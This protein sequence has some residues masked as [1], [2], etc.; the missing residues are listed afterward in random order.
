MKHNGEQQPNSARNPDAILAEIQR[1]RGEMDSTLTALE[2][3]LTPGQLVD[4]GIDYLRKSGANE[5]VQN[6]G[7]QAKNNPM[8]IALVG[9]GL[10]WLM[11]SG[12]Q[13]PSRSTSTS[14]IDAGGSSIGNR[15]GE[16]RQ[17]AAGVAQSAKEKMTQAGDQ[18]RAF[19]DTA[20]SQVERAKGSMEYMLREQPLALGA[21]GVAIGAVLA[22]MAPRTRQEDELMGETR[23]RLVD[24]A[25]EVGKEKVEQ[26]KEVANAVVGTAKNEAKSDAG[27]AEW[28]APQTG[29]KPAVTPKPNVTPKP[30]SSGNSSGP[31]GTS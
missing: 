6:L 19:G 24:Q 27:K 28:P 31:R 16:L 14:Y 8:P 25:K 20:R 26:A 9:I 11:A 21:I 18:V 3:R 17:Q 2:Q 12:K 15:A 7:V 4:Q 13:P 23:D 1:T 5:F 10:A 29:S 22:A 30:P